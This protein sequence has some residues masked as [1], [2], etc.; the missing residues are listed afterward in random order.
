MFIYFFQYLCK[1]C[2]NNKAFLKFYMNDRP[3][4]TKCMDEYNLE[5]ERKCIFHI[6]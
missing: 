2:A 4:C 3:L 6:H 1:G 5:N